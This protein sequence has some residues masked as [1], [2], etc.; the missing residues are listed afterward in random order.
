[1]RLEYSTDTGEFE[2][3]ACFDLKQ[4]DTYLNVDKNMSTDIFP[5]FTNRKYLHLLLDEWL[6]WAKRQ[7]TIP[8]ED[9]YEYEN[10]NFHVTICKEN[11]SSD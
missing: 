4:L 11:H 10:V 3:L 9:I 7:E 2:N 5:F 8:I 6:N 1:M